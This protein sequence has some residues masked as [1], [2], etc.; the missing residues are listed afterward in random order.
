MGGA[1]HRAER[2]PAASSG[3]G[4][5]R[6]HRALPAPLHTPLPIPHP[7][8]LP[9]PL[10][11]PSSWFNSAA[12]RA[13]PAAGCPKRC[14]AGPSLPGPTCFPGAVASTSS[15][16]GPARPGGAQRLS[17]PSGRAAPRPRRRSAAGQAAAGGAGMPGG[18][19][20]DEASVLRCSGPSA[21]A[22]QLR[23]RGGCASHARRGAVRL[24]SARCGSPGLGSAQ[25][26]SA[27]LGAAGRARVSARTR[28]A[29][30]GGRGAGKLRGAEAGAERGPSA[31][32][33][34]GGGPG[35]A[36]APRPGCD[37]VS[38]GIAG[39]SRDPAGDR[40]VPPSPG[41]Q[42]R[43]P[44]S[45]LESFFPR[46]PRAAARRRL[47]G[48]KPPL[49]RWALAQQLRTPGPRCRRGEP[50]CPVQPD[51]PGGQHGSAGSIRALRA[52]PGVPRS[53]AAPGR[54]PAR[55]PVERARLL[56]QRA[57]P[58]GRAGILLPRQPWESFHPDLHSWPAGTM[59]GQ[60][61]ARSRHRRLGPPH[62]EIRSHH[63]IPFGWKCLSCSVLAQRQ[64][65][66]K[67]SVRGEAL[68]IL[69][70]VSSEPDA[71]SLFPGVLPVRSDII[72]G[73]L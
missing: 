72:P 66:T 29:G 37:S 2:G 70:C 34:S 46:T 60:A 19:G 65:S 26:G 47:R 27:R 6:L 9:S 59:P 53:S 57:P 18:G 35:L 32:R 73:V 49:R 64:P 11:T 13:R 36:P 43:Q 12:P 16:L 56:L 48:S 14:P 25:L 69:G 63:R 61:G 54:A 15:R 51:P 28:G 30:A 44:L 38:V 20:E 67:G 17:A 23:A 71:F 3:S 58:A 7:A 55:C 10:P 22:G 52:G 42:L 5:R 31:P 41:R 68:V 50:R 21:P 62:R 1:R 45:P 40:P 24:G 33:P 4:S 8:P 39:Q